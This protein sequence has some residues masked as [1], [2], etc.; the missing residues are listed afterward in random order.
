MN[1]D[2]DKLYRKFV[3]FNEIYN[4]LVQTF[5]FEVIL[6]LKKLIYCPDLD[7]EN[8]DLDSILIF[9]AQDN[10]KWKSLKYKVV[11]LVKNYKF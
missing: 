3:A 6:R 2:G 4:F 5:S 1:S 11:D 9:G 7:T 8:W 10:F